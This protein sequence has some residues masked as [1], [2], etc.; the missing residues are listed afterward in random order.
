MGK[1]KMAAEFT[2]CTLRI[3]I[4]DMVVLRV[5]TGGTPN[6]DLPKFLYQV[7][8]ARVGSL[9]ATIP[10]GSHGVSIPHQSELG[11]GYPILRSPPPTVD[12]FVIVY[13]RQTNK[14]YEAIE[15]LSR[16]LRYKITEFHEI[17]AGWI[18]KDEGVARPIP[19]R[20]AY[21]LPGIQLWG[22]ILRDSG[23]IASDPSVLSPDITENMQRDREQLAGSGILVRVP[24]LAG[25]KT[26]TI[27][28]AFARVELTQDPQPNQ[29]SHWIDFA[30]YQAAYERQSHPP[31]AIV[32]QFQ[33]W[34]ETLTAESGFQRFVF[35]SGMFFGDCNE[36]WGERNR[37]RTMHEGLDF[38]E[39]ITSDAKT[40]SIPVGTPVRAMA[41]GEVVAI[42][43]DFLGKTVIV[44]HP[45]F[46]NNNG[47]IFHTLYSH[48]RPVDESFGPVEKGRHLGQMGKSPNSRT[49]AHLH[50]TGAWIPGTMLP[51]AI[52]MNHINPG[53]AAVTLTSFNDLIK[54]FNDPL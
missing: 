16:G 50:L 31:S 20:Y 8:P 39:G 49:P 47:D 21:F 9:M 22:V 51:D 52:R 48:I 32:P 43:N 27:L 46:I 14:R 6:S 34:L 30:E 11:F 24:V 35:K 40:G 38:V 17:A 23:Y 28:P 29:Q 15:I 4:A 13:S 36:W 25:Q 1:V 18:E 12:G 42:L 10:C 3:S 26:G 53:F 44:R 37:R 19:G 33:E 5:R 2:L 41:D 54:R 45:E 7:L